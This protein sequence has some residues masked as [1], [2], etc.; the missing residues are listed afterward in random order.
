MSPPTGEDA[1]NQHDWGQLLHDEGPWLARHVGERV[2]ADAVEDVL[3]EV[4]ASFWAA[5]V[6]YRDEGHRR[7]FLRTLADRR[8]A[9]W[10]RAA[11]APGPWTGAPDGAGDPDFTS[12]LL[13]RSGVV[14]G[15]LLWRRVVDDWTLADLARHFGLPVGT[16]KSRLHYQSQ[17][18]RRHLH[19]WYQEAR[20]GDSACSHAR[21]DLWG[22]PPCPSC[23]RDRAG[24]HLLASVTDP[25]APFQLTYFTWDS[26]LGL[27][28][29]AR[30][31]FPWR[32]QSQMSRAY[33]CSRADFGPITQL[34][35]VRGES[36]LGRVRRT[37]SV[38]APLWTY[39]LYP[40]DGSAFRVST[41][42]SAADAEHVGALESGRHQVQLRTDIS[43]HDGGS[44]TTVIELPPTLIVQQAT[45]PPHHASRVHGRTVLVWRDCAALPRAPVVY[46]HV[47]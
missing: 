15:S 26:A 13:Q 23:Q 16:I 37:V 28:L 30:C 11:S 2:P 9:D 40:R 33:G 7:A 45:P 14:P 5:G 10:H 21:S 36:L 25:D 27:S 6:H 1:V 4:W 43:Y 22:I 19:E 18:L 32:R 39:D 17:A 46:A 38:D 42:G 35:S 34:R 24:W 29:D 47:V 12:H 20:S 31:H 8:A 3:Q 41:H 44:G